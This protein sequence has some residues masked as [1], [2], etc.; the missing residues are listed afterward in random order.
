MAFLPIRTEVFQR[1]KITRI[2]P[3]YISSVSV[4]CPSLCFPPTPPPIQLGPCLVHADQEGINEVLRGAGVQHFPVPLDALNDKIFHFLNFAVQASVDAR[5]VFQDAG[6]EFKHLQ[7]SKEVPESVL[8][9]LVLQ[10]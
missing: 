4:V 2:I 3:K 5:K 6:E 9:G 1:L 10:G 8:S 7:G